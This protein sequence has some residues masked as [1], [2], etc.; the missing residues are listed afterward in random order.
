MIIEC[1]PWLVAELLKSSDTW[2]KSKYRFIIELKKSEF[3]EARPQV[4]R[5][6]Y[7]Q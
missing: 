5:L 2:K 6:G 1:G 3:Q 4:Y 7:I